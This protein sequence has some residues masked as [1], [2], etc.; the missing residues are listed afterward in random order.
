MES[1]E[2]HPCIYAQLIFKEGVKNIQWRKVSLFNSV[3]LGKL[4]VH[5]QKNK[6]GPLDHT[7]QL[8]MD[9]RFEWRPETIKLLEEIIG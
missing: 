9:E 2:V 5:M 7:K 6:I 8:K 4:N 1:P 3:V